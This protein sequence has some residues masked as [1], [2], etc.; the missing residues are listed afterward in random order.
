MHGQIAG[1]NHESDVIP[2][3]RAAKGAG[4]GEADQLDKA[5]K[6]FCSWSKGP[7][8][9]PTKTADTRS[10]WLRSFRINC[11]PPKIGSRN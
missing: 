7:R 1:D 11:E 3:A 9:L 6:Q 8:G 5:G 4:P 10:A 2:F